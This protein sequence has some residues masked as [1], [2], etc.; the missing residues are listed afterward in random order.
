MIKDEYKNWL[1]KQKDDTNLIDSYGPIYN[2][3]P[4]QFIFS[5]GDIKMI[6]QIAEYVQTTVRQRGYGYFKGKTKRCLPNATR[7]ETKN[8]D[9]DETGMQEKLFNGV[10]D[11]LQPYGK[12]VVALFKREMVVVT[13]EDGVI[14]GCVRCVL[15]DSLSEPERKKK[16]RRQEFGENW[17]GYKQYWNGYSWCLSNFANHHLRNVHPIQNNTNQQT[18]KND[19]YEETSGMN[20][21]Q[22]TSPT[23]DLMKKFYKEN[24]IDEG[25]LRFKKLLSNENT[26]SNYNTDNDNG[27]DHSSL[28]EL[29][30]EQSN[31]DLND[32]FKIMRD[33]LRA[34]LQ[35]HNVQLTNTFQNS[36]NGTEFEIE[37]S[38][39]KISK[40]E[41]HQI[42]MDGDC[43]FG[44]SVHQRFHLEVGSDEY[45]EKTVQLRNDV[46]TQ[47][48]MDSK[49]YERM[50]LDRIYHTQRING[51]QSKILNV[52][53]ECKHFLE[54]KLAKECYWGGT[55]SIEA[56]SEIFK[57][58]VVVFKDCGEVYFG[59]SFNSLYEDIITLS[60]RASNRIENASND[61]TC[62]HY[63]SIVKLSADLLEKSPSILMEKFLKTCSIKNIS[64]VIDIE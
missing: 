22:S 38:A 51:K 40:F 17:N 64:D 60:F 20:A 59:N 46:V 63:D 31:I 10:S 56:I 29:Q 34:Q 25:M 47:I 28:M 30:I 19:Y 37:L 43:L 33:N 11:L 7:C 54:N 4:E 27:E 61:T 62:D 26:D 14:N 42:P 1:D 12:D 50:L 15:C 45:K 39:G 6:R 58:N 9:A 23:N 55:E 49:R 16:R 41:V 52:E 57:A 35:F 21:T 53:E 32:E 8:S 24:L 2:S 13:N 48:S 36:E 18:K 5:C 44:A 3:K